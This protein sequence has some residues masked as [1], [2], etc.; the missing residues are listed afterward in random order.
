MKTK[1]QLMTN[2]AKGEITMEQAEELYKKTEKV[3]V[4]SLN[5]QNAPINAHKR[6]KPTKLKEDNK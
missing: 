2:V 6:R 5:K 4:R 3:A 1:K